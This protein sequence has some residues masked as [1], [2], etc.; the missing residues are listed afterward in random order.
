MKAEGQYPPSTRLGPGISTAVPTEGTAAPGTVSKLRRGVGRSGETTQLVECASTWAP[1]PTDFQK[2]HTQ[3]CSY[4]RPSPPS[5]KAGQ[6]APAHRDLSCVWGDQAIGVPTAR[7]LG[8][9][10]MSPLLG[11]NPGTE[12]ECSR[13]PSGYKGIWAHGIRLIPKLETLYMMVI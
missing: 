4:Q 6:W 13:T 1:I 11:G 5:Y 3:A 8:G 12:V 9:A 2:D 10:I 7:L